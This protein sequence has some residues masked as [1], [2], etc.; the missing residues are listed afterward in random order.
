MGMSR[1]SKTAIYP[2]YNSMGAKVLSMGGWEMP[3]YFTHPQQEYIH[4]RTKA[5]LFDVGHIGKILVQGKHAGELLQFITTNDIRKLKTE[6][7]QYSTV[8]NDRG[9]I[10]DDILIYKL[11]DDK[12]MLT[13]NSTRVSLLVSWMYGHYKGPVQIEDITLQLSSFS[14]QGP[15]AQRIMSKIVPEA[16]RISHFGIMVSNIAD[17]GEVIISR[18][19]FTGEDGFELYVAK[20]KA[21]ILWEQIMRS[22]SANLLAPIGLIALDFLRLEA[23]LSLYGKELTEDTSPYEVGLSSVVQLDKGPFIGKEALENLIRKGV[24]KKLF[25]LEVHDTLPSAG[26]EVFVSSSVVGHVTSSMHSSWLDK[27][28]A[29]A[30]IDTNISGEFDVCK[31][32]IKDQYVTANKVNLPF[33]RAESN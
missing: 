28:I 1:L 20:D 2:L 14:L 11:S 24:T 13:V 16:G 26:S 17:I 5:G 3:M 12:Y 6:R 18:S 25:G 7:I 29:I 31:I 8:C 9:G 21:A 23:G 10:L 30:R 32:K 19:G 22:E 4:V 15:L 33:Y 27:F